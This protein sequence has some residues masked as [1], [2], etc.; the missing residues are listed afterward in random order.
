[1]SRQGDH[2]HEWKQSAHVHFQRW[3]HHYD[4]GMINIL[5]F[6]PSHRR[7]LAQIRHWLRRGWE[8][9]RILDIGCGTGTLLMHCLA[10]G[11]RIRS[12][13]GLDM[14][15]N[16]L[17]YA[18]EKAQLC[19]GQDRLAFTLGDA[20]HLPFPEAY[21]DLITCCNSFH[22][23]PHQDRA[24][25]EMRRVLRPGGRLILIDGCRDDPL[26][27]FIFDICVARAE[28]HV[29]HCS[30]RRFERLLT[31]AGFDTVDQRVF[32]ICPPAIMNI[33]GVEK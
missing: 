20:E 12:G 15:E 28:N 2:R 33:A 19:D 32:G 4:R 1:M 24:A 25:G 14:S 13:F 18:R 5:L 7:V 9:I 16:M 17:H 10:F 27:H 30:A 31:Q 23:Y 26:G 3:A 22:H 11:D 8:P 21:F 6:N 29:H